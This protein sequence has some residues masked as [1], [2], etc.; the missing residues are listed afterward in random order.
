LVTQGIATKQSFARLVAG[1][2]F[3]YEAME[4]A[5]DASTDPCVTRP[6]VWSRAQRSSLTVA[7]HLSP[8]FHFSPSI[9]K[10]RRSPQRRPASS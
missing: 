7:L 3:V 2:Y 5:F 9:T 8:A 1:L 6:P 10:Y 4:D